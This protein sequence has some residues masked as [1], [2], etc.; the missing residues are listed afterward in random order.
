[1]KTYEQ[2]RKHPEYR[3]IPIP[4]MRSLYAY[5]EQH[6]TP[7]GFLLAVLSNDLLGAVSRADKEALTAIRALML[8]LYNEVPAGGQGSPQKVQAWLAQRCS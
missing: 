4:I 5:I 3:A 6:V 2:A 7:G 1:M 8:F